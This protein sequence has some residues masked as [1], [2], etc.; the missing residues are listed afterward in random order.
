MTEETEKELTQQRESSRTNNL[1]VSSKESSTT[2]D[3]IKKAAMQYASK[4]LWVLPIS[5]TSKRPMIPFAER[6]EPLTVEE[7]EQFWDIHPEA[8]IALQTVDFFVID[9]DRHHGVDGMD[10]L[11]ALNHQ[12]WFANTLVETTAHGGV[13]IYFM[14]PTDSNGKPIQMKQQI[15]WRKGIDI[16]CNPHNYVV[17]S[18]SRL[19]DRRYQWINKK[20]M[21]TAPQGLM[22]LILK[23][24]SNNNSIISQYNHYNTG[25][26]NFTSHKGKYLHLIAN[27][28]GDEGSRNK[29]LASLIG[30]LIAYNDDIDSAMKLAIEANEKTADPLP[31][32]EV[33]R[34]I[35]SVLTIEMKK[36][37]SNN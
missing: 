23:N 21:V 5:P 20:P 26:A 36:R 18:P 10:A 25:N 28:L 16:K 1:N 7:V 4:G 29:N 19:G 2:D 27:G 3:S 12:E 14:K 30:W 17:V 37:N 31:P 15:A 9:V 32:R 24:D 8:N 35:Q 22:S 11:K 34:T 13:H 33:N 6:K